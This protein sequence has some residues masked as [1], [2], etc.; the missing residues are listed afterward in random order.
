M[1]ITID[2]IFKLMF[3]IILFMSYNVTLYGYFIPNYIV[4]SIAILVM[5]L[6]FVMQL[7]NTNYTKK[8]MLYIFSIFLIFIIYIFRNKQL[9]DNFLSCTLYLLVFFLMLILQSSDKWIKI[10]YKIVN[11]FTLE[12]VIG[13]Y[14]VFLFPSLYETLFLPIFK[15]SSGYADLINQIHGNMNAGFTGNYGS[16]SNYLTLGFIVLFSKCIAKKKFKKTDLIM[17]SVILLA[18]FMTGKRGPL[19]FGII[20]I[21]VEYLF[22]NKSKIP[23]KLFKLSVGG[24][25]AG[26]LLVI[27]SNFVPSIAL[28]CDRLF[29][30]KD[31]L[32]G[33][34]QLYNYAL[35]LFNEHT[36]FGIG[37]GNFKYYY[38][39]YYNSAQLLNV[40]NVYLQLLCETGIIG[41]I[42]ILF[43]MIKSVLKSYKMQKQEVYSNYREELIISF[44][45]QLFV[46]L[47]GVSSTPLY[48][49][50]LLYIYIIS[51]VIPFAISLN[52]KGEENE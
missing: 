22:T 10:P 11:F 24:I 49:I 23:N 46:I 25:I 48:G 33:R 15:S 20:T 19:V 47:I 36:F 26:T 21:I 17:L 52:K 37:W 14:F 4:I 6:V 9:I 2:K 34:E 1:K 18:I 16:N 45:I 42:I 7:K 50:E 12:H 32:N 27:V 31:I 30:S 39:A 38:S 28:V 29:N 5:G 8:N 51:C 41:T 3:F 35:K 44:A 13:T 43:Y 40:H